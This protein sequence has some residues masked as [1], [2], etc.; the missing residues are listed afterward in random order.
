M[1]LWGFHSTAFQGCRIIYFKHRVALN[2]ATVGVQIST[3][4]KLPFKPSLFEVT[5]PP[6]VTLAAWLF[7]LEG[8]TQRL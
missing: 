8:M 1:L 4:R 2:H 7:V 6:H 3:Q 5:S